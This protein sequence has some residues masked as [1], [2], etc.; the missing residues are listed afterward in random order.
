[1]APGMNGLDTYR[2]ALEI[3]PNQKAIITSGYSETDS[4]CQAQALG[5]GPYVK[6]PY[7]IEKIGVAVKKELAKD[8]PSKASV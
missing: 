2:G 6:K 3:A 8:H 7:T 1:M 5:A 4:V